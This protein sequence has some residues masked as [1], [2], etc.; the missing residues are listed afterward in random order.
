MNDFSPCACIGLG[1]ETAPKE[2]TK[3]IHM[4]FYSTIGN[5]TTIAH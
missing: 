1:R 2:W 4:R 5:E 3:E